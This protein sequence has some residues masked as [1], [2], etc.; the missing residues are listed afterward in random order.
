MSKVKRY[1]FFSGWFGGIREDANGLWCNYDEADTRYREL[2]TRYKELQK[3]HKPVAI[4]TE[5]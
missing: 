3:Q 4:T 2:Q 5:V 1:N